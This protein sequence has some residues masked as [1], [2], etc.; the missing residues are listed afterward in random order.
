MRSKEERLNPMSCLNQAEPDELTFVLLGRDVAAPSTIRA[1]AHERVRLG[2]NK[3]KDAQIV[4]AL[5]CADLMEKERK[6]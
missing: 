1:W 3:S 4:E 5:A 6:R 2:K